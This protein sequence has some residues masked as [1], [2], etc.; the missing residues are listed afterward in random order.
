[1]PESPFMRFNSPETPY[2]PLYGFRQRY[3]NVGFS[4]KEEHSKD[5][6]EGSVGW[7]R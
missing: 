2:P 7:F 1:M 3:F 6:V 5:E 4:F